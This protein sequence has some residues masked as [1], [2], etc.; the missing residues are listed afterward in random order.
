ML[1]QQ[2]LTHVTKASFLCLFV[3]TLREAVSVTLSQL[4]KILLI[5]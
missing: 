2:T 5:D 1:A 4:D 3:A